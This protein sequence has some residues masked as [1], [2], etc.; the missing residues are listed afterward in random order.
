MTRVNYETLGKFIDVDTIKWVGWTLG[1][2]MKHAVMKDFGY[3]IRS[4]A[5]P[6]E[7]LTPMDRLK[8]FLRISTSL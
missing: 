7:D 5:L 2:M 6:A 4:Y 3:G 1:K 8:L